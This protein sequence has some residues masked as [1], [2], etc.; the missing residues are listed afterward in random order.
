MASEAGMGWK[1]LEEGSY[2][3][4][5]SGRF[6]IAFI[7]PAGVAIWWLSML[8]A[9][10]VGAIFVTSTN[11]QA[12]SPKAPLR[13]YLDV[14]L[15][16][17]RA[18]GVAIEQGVRTAL[19]QD[20]GRF[21]DRPVQLV[22]L[23]NHGNSS[24]SLANLK[25]F[26]TDPNGLAIIG[27]QH[28]A[29]LLAHRNYINDNKILM[30]V[31]WATAAPI[32]RPKEQ[33]NWIFRLSID[34]QMVGEALVG[35]AVD[36]R[37]FSRLAL[38]LEESDWGKSNFHRMNDSLKDRGLVPV[39]TSYLAWGV[40]VPSA[41]ILLREIYRSGADAIL[42][43][44]TAQE[45]LAV[46]QA[47]LNQPEDER[48]PVISHW[49]V[50]GVDVSGALPHHARKKLDLEFVQTRFSFLDMEQ[51][52]L[53]RQVFEQAQTLFPDIKRPSDI[54]PPNG[55]THAYDITRILQAA[56]RQSGL[57][58]DVAQDRAAVRAALENLGEPVEGLI[59]VYRKPFAPFDAESTDGHEALNLNDYTFGRFNEHDAI[60][61]SR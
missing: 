59:K 51:G 29:P 8:L 2:S 26:Q 40:S 54:T 49:R 37:G 12:V 4:K 61:L 52:S 9:L 32:T 57:T 27:G 30:L 18:S 22:V 24:R 35:R 5:W 45:E 10:S 50:T 31:P 14:D 42:M 13:L 56:V 7:Y 15:T 19:A 33:N 44:A 43:D 39:S 41:N 21:G 23:D 25:Q 47:M 60:I 16:G 38:L 58:G 55:F 53:G 11:S 46:L 6:V 20:G 36:E 34:D 3:N 1:R 17:A 28:S 48:L